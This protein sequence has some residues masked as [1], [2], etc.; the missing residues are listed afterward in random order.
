MYRWI[1]RISDVKD[2]GSEVSQVRRLAEMKQTYKNPE[3]KAT[4]R[5]G[6]VRSYIVKTYQANYQ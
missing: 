6:Q 4:I 2:K 1:P 5:K 3:T